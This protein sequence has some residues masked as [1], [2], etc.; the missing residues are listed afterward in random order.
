MSTKPIKIMHL[1]IAV[2]PDWATAASKMWIW[3]KSIERF[4]YRFY[5][6]GVG[7]KQ[8]PGYRRQK[9][10]SQLQHL[11]QYGTGDATHV[12]YTDCCDCL[13]L[14]GPEEFESKYRAMGCPP[15]LVQASAQL[16]N[17][18]DGRY[19]WFD[20]PERV[21]RLGPFRYPCVGG[22]VMEVALLREWLMKM[23]RDYPPT[24]PR[25]GDD[26][27]VWYEGFEKGWF[28]PEMDSK[29]EL[30]R[31]GGEESM[32]VVIG[33]QYPRLY[34]P[35]TDSMPV[36]WHNSGGSANQDTFKDDMMLPM[37]RRLGIV[38]ETEVKPCS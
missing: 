34:S 25:W 11:L 17:V 38:G 8:W 13:M 1:G 3:T 7:T 12:H 22:Y 23:H 2:W 4:G 31:V 24:D 29:C 21:E 9:V 28:R 30:W 19:G 27:F 18:S 26:C 35:E 6:Y 36:I 32:Q 16:G 15:M 37:A 20:E 5:Y 14:G 10:E 33:G